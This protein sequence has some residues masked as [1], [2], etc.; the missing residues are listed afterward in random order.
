[1]KLLSTRYI[2]IF[3]VSVLIATGI[4]FF[5]GMQFATPGPVSGNN[6]KAE[7]ASMTETRSGGYRFINP[8][9]EC[10][11]FTSTSNF[12]VFEM[13]QEVSN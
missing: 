9:L 5:A 8:L 3:A 7:P 10:D 11:A 12:I 4:G 2:V 6:N 1:M 13:E